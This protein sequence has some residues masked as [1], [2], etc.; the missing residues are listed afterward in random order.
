MANVKAQ[1]TGAQAAFPQ[2]QVIS[3]SGDGGFTMLTDDLLSL[4][5][6]NLPVRAIVFNNG[7][8]GFI[9]L[10]QQSSG[11]LDTGTELINPN[12]AAAAEA[13]VTNGSTYRGSGGR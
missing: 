2:R 11:F 3:F 13:V 7:G 9:E 10:E 8:L 12:F 1:S 6:L 4:S 5:Q